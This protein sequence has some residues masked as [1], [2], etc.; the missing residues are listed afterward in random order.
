[1]LRDYISILK[2]LKSSPDPLSG[3][4]AGR[5]LGLYNTTATSR[6]RELGEFGLVEQAYASEHIHLWVITRRGR[7]FLGLLET[8]DAVGMNGARGD[9]AAQPDVEGA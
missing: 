5:A 6:L 4:A 3:T 1:M 9:K 7:A 8:L 2:A